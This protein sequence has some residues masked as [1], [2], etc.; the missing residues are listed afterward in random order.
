M[1]LAHL[2]AFSHS[3][4]SRTQWAGKHV[5]VMGLGRHGGGEG[6]VRYLAGQG[7]LVTIS[8]AS[9][10]GTLEASLARL[11]DVPFVG[12]KFGAH[13]PGDFRGAD[14]VVVNPAVRPDHSC[15]RMARGAG[16]MLT[17]EIEIFLRACPA[18][19]VGVTGTNGKSTTSTMLA[20]IFSA[21]GRRTWLGGNLGGSLLDDVSRIAADDWVILELSSFQLAHLSDTAPLPRFAVVTN[22]V[23]NHL[24]WH[25]D[26]DD[27]ARAKKRLVAGHGSRRI[28]VLNDH[29]SSLDDWRLPE[30]GQCLGAWPLERLPRLR[31]PGRHNQQ[32]AAC[33]AAAAEVAGIDAAAI[34]AALASYGGLPHRLQLVGE[35]G[36][37]R[38]YNDSKSTTPEAT[39]AALVA[40][41]GPVWLLAGGQPK[42]A[43]FDALA[44]ALCAR[45]RGAA[46]F[47][48]ARRALDANIKSR[49]PDFPTSAT[50][51]LADALAWC[52]RA[53]RPG[54]AILLSPAY[55]SHDQFD[56]F[57]ARGEAFCRLIADLP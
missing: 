13:D 33:A 3:G 25:V 16:A 56:D 36:G 27:Y 32:N 21:A 20:G 26:F 37:R 1:T 24:D 15:L 35:I 22:C 7:A 49:C 40:I 28:A 50:E 43:S 38:F 18:T 4:K 52:W 9:A 10:R 55:A 45:A 53:S 30:R 31:V 14:C 41:E 54:D 46:L 42:G 6:A 47:G 44:G 5:T 51:H 23:P 17:S 34:R 29:D 8:D 12:L 19:V 2:A 39:L 48:A 11:A 57:N